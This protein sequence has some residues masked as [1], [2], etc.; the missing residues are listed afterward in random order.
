MFN[1]LKFVIADVAKPIN[2]ADLLYHHSLAVCSINP[3]SRFQTPI[4]RS[5]AMGGTMFAAIVREFHSI[6]SATNAQKIIQ[7]EVYHLLLTED[8][9]VFQ[10]ARRL[11][12]D[13]L[14]EDKKGI[15]RPSRS[16]WETLLHMR[17]IIMVVKRLCG[18]CRRFNAITTPE[19]CPIPH[20]HYFAYTLQGFTVFSNVD[21]TRSYQQYTLCGKY[22]QNRSYWVVR[23]LFQDFWAT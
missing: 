17:T 18:D 21:L 22:P 11:P 8:P 2:G 9:P 13:K 14:N 6:T 7:V 10:R 23:I 15:F 4:I 3:P 16:N 12:P 1:Q 19:R 5:V 20:L